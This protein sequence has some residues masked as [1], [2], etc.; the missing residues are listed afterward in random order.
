MARTRQLGLL[1]IQFGGG[2]SGLV[3]W[4]LL[5]Q[6]A[7]FRVDEASRAL[8]VGMV[9]YLPVTLGLPFLLPN[10]YR[11]SDLQPDAARF[12]IAV[13]VANGSAALVAGATFRA[14]GEDVGALA[15]T[16]AGLIAVS[17]TLQQVSRIRM[18]LLGMAVASTYTVALPGGVLLAA[19][20]GESNWLTQMIM[21]ALA[22]LVVGMLLRERR[23]LRRRGRRGLP[24]NTLSRALPLLPHM[25]A[26]A[27]LTQG[28]RVPYTLAREPMVPEHTVMLFVGFALAVI[29]GV[30]S[31]LTVNIQVAAESR[32]R[33]AMRQNLPRYLGLGLLGAIGIVA[34]YGSPARELF[35]GSEPLSALSLAMLGSVPPAFS[36][37]FFSTAIL[38]RY[39]R[40]GRLATITVPVATAYTGLAWA[41]AERTP[42]LS[43]QVAIY[44]GSLSAMA[45]GTCVAA[46][47]L[48]PRE[49]SSGSAVTAGRSHL[50]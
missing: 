2:I 20:V 42:S 50:T 11:A 45:C 15:C 24:I 32:V 27:V 5:S 44:A 39:G 19:S 43:I 6:T 35:A 25:A 13:V 16:L 40:S 49:S 31:L 41:A 1:A 47:R 37:Y 36:V 18:S 23:T 38:M 26:F 21:A 22:G 28:I 12:S 34:T 8:A 9:L 17:A 46:A 3:L 30:N 10:H 29:T 4:A 14:L 33:L 7:V 48:Y